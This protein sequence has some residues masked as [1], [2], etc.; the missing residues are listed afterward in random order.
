MKSNGGFAAKCWKC[1]KRRGGKREGEENGGGVGRQRME[2]EEG[3]GRE[4]KVEAG[5][6]KFYCVSFRP[7]H[8]SALF[9]SRTSQLLSARSFS[10]SLSLSRKHTAP[11]VKE[12]TRDDDVCPALLNRYSRNGRL[13]T[14][15][16]TPLE[17]GIT[18]RGEPPRFS[19]PREEGDV[20]KGD[21][22]YENYITQAGWP[23]NAILF[24]RPRF[25]SLIFVKRVSTDSQNFCFNEGRDS[26]MYF[27]SEKFKILIFPNLTRIWKRRISSNFHSRPARGRRWVRKRNADRQTLDS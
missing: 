2:D 7:L 23:R 9:R 21:T 13:V 26:A 1:W 18:R 11:R 16:V 5:A 6:D 14:R 22:L 27:L 12:E 24:F 19:S 4:E 10:L 20:Q 17:D 3:R 25:S 15:L 8:L